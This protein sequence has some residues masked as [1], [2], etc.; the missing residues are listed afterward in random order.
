M[1]KP[2]PNEEAEPEAPEEGAPGLLGE[3]GAPMDG[4]EQP[5]VA[6]EEQ[7]IYSE[8][9]DKCYLVLYSPKAFK[10]TIDSLNATDDPKMNL[11][12][13]VVV[14]VKHVSDSARKAGKQIP[15][16][17]LMH[18]GKEVMEDMAD[19]SAKVGLHEFTPDELEG[20]VYIAMD[21]FREM[22]KADGTFD[23]EGA[24]EDVRTAMMAEREG[25]LDE[26]IPGASE[27]AA[28]PAED[29]PMEE[30]DE[31]VEEEEPEEDE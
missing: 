5:N 11:A 18:G 20:A 29:E 8:F 15:V 19:L 16:D 27:R 22:Q 23:E 25:R 6:P 26:V 7:D 1:K 21:L 14:A 2:M 31:P 3:E 10:Q 17:V 4:E 12:N 28:P 24:K 30:E 9:V 13:I